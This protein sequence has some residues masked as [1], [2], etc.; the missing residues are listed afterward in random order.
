MSDMKKLLESFDSIS[1]VDESSQFDFDPERNTII[2]ATKHYHLADV[3]PELMY[4]WA[5]TDKINR[6]CFIAWAAWLME[7]NYY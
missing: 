6:K 3:S 2:T 4:E 7:S 1:M 5:K